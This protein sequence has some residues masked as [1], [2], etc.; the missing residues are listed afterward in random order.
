MQ[1]A[2]C[3]K[4]RAVKALKK[5][6]NDIVNAIMD[7]TMWSPSASSARRCWITH[8]RHV[9]TRSL[10]RVFIEM[11]SIFGTCSILHKFILFILS[12]RLT[13]SLS[14]VLPSF[15]SSSPID[16]SP[17]KKTRFINSPCLVGSLSDRRRGGGGGYFK[18]SGFPSL[19]IL[20]HR[21]L[22]ILDY[23]YL[24]P[25]VFALSGSWSP[26]LG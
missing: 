5:C 15:Y 22:S 17:Y 20:E 16:R 12:A 18:N 3:S 19:W 7:L 4:G 9:I 11:A 10:A 6:D 23:L 14:F 2:N 26:G 1:Q 21:T 13:I 25:Y 8:R 24:S